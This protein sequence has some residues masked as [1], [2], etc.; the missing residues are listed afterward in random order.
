MYIL[1]PVLIKFVD[2]VKLGASAP[3]GL[4]PRRLKIVS[5]A[6]AL[7]TYEQSYKRV[8]WIDIPHDGVLPLQLFPSRYLQSPGHYSVSLYRPGNTLPEYTQVWEV[9]VT[10]SYGTLELI[11]GAGSSDLLPPEV[12]C[13]ISIP[14]YDDWH[15]GDGHI[16]WGANQPLETYTVSYLIPLTLAQVVRTGVV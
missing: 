4:E 6:T 5:P 15:V 7:P 13:D 8:W 12:F 9:P 11:R 10:T 16:V 3:A 14:G 1:T 2:S